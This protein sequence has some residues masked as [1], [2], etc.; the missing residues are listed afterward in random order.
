MEPHGNLRAWENL[1][2]SKAIWIVGQPG[3]GKTT[4]VRALLKG[5]LTLHPKPKW[6]L[7]ENGV[8][9]AGHY[10]GGKFDG[11][12]TVP[13]NGVKD[14]LEYWRDN[15]RGFPLAVFDGDRFSHESA[16][17]F[18]RSAGAETLCVLLNTPGAVCAERRLKRG[19]AQNESWVKGRVTK[20][21]RFFEQFDGGKFVAATSDEALAYIKQQLGV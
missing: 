6:T 11:A 3:S 10:N 8:V 4:L 15:L 19:S 13:Y 1:R 21:I 18:A 16:V 9:A 2:V 12:D 20:S 17:S 7:D 5:P 14:A